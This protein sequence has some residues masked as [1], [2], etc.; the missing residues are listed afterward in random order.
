[1][2]VNFFQGMLRVLQVHASAASAAGDPAEALKTPPKPWPGIKPVPLLAS[3]AV[4]MVLRF[5]VPVPT[6]LS[7]QAWTLLSIFVSTI[8]GA[9]STLQQAV[10]AFC[11]CDAGTCSK[12][13]LWA[14][15]HALPYRCWIIAVLL[16]RSC[17]H[18]E[19]PLCL[20][21]SIKSCQESL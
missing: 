20:D 2:L 19:E 4:G 9:A 7:T 17:A 14:Q 1:M 5:L 12:A 18:L 6:G 13:T 3:V 15:E 8:A 11:M 16:D 10:K 21:P